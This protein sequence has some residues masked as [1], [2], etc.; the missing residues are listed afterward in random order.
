MRSGTKITKHM[1]WEKEKRMI[2]WNMG[3]RTKQEGAY[4][5]GNGMGSIPKR[6]EIRGA[7]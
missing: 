4:G 2:V 7:R 3:R 5:K 6:W 1:D